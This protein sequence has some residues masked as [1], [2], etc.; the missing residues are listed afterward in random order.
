LGG[1][2]IYSGLYKLA[3]PEPFERTVHS[4]G[5]LSGPVSSIISSVLPWAQLILGAFLVS[6]QAISYTAPIV[7]I[8]LLMF[9]FMNTL[10]ASKGNCQNCGFSS[11]LVFYKRGNPFVL[12]TINY[13][14]L[15]LSG[16]LVMSKTLFSNKTRPS[17][18]KRVVIPLS[19]WVV[20]FIILILFT[21]MGRSSYE[22]EYISAVSKERSQVEEEMRLPDNLKL[23]GTE[24]GSISN[25]EFPVNPGIRITVMLTLQS[26]DCG[27]C[28]DE[29][30]YLE[31][32]NVKYGR[33]IGF[34]AV[35]RKIG[36]TA[37]DDFKSRYS[38]SY[39]LI[40][41]PTLLD[42]R[43]Y[44]RYKSL[45]TIISNDKKIMRIDP[46]SFNIKGFKDEYESVLVSYL[47]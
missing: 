47:Q 24:L 13:L 8:L 23:I 19:I 16:T 38:I 5:F 17:L 30:A 6:G 20:V 40:E 9:I 35:V 2:F 45:M 12:L 34:C 11:E 42:F 3:N 44:S 28:A 31:Y 1:I 39:P 26:L 10:M 29:A 36:K 21:F 46:I 37:I 27:N 7:S 33:T 41:D 18:P 32:L 15:A 14:L 25:T 4:F 22:G 43:I